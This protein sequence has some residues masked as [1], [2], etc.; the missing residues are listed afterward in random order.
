MNVLKYLKCGPVLLHAVC[1]GFAIRVEGTAG[2]QYSK[3]SF[4]NTNTALSCFSGYWILY[5]N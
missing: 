5:S 1:D 4:G 2:V 3:K